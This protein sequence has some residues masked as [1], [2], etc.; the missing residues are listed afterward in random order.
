MALPARNGIRQRFDPRGADQCR[1]HQRM[2]CAGVRL[3]LAVIAADDEA[4]FGAR[5]ADIQQ[6]AIFLLCRLP[7]PRRGGARIVVRHHCRGAPE[8]AGA[9]PQ[10]ALRCERQQARQ[11]LL[12][13]RPAA[14]V[15]QEDDRRLQALCGMRRHDAH[16]A[17]ALIHLALDLGRGTF[18]RRQEGFEPRRAG[19]F[20]GEA[21]AQELV[22]DVACFRS[23]TGDQPAPDAVAA[24]HA[25]IEVEHR[26]EGSLAAPLLELHDD[27]RQ[28]RVGRRPAPAVPGR[29]RRPACGHARLRTTRPPRGRRSGCAAMRPATD[30]HAAAARRGQARR[31]P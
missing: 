26:L 1:A 13:E 11:M 3:L 22:D 29:A 12:A 5:H 16:L 18:E 6:A 24:E 27:R 7:D 15:D 4:V 31:G 10:A 19:L 28:R 23:E 2:P 25:G 9:L 30:R 21:E 14:I 8:I 20:L 17:A